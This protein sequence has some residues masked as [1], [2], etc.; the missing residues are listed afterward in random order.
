MIAFAVAATLFTAVPPPSAWTATQPTVEDARAEAAAAFE[1]GKAA[2]EREDFVEAVAQFSVAQAR[3]PHPSTAYNLGL[4]QARAGAPLEA[5]RTFAALREQ[6][7]SQLRADAQRQLDLLADDVAR[8]RV[9]APAKSSLRLDG[10][11]I[12]PDTVVLRRPGPAMVSV[13]GR[14]VRLTLR[15]GEL[16]HLDLRDAPGTTR[17]SSPPSATGLLAATVA[18]TAATAGVGVASILLRDDDI[19]PPLAWTTVGLGTAATALA[20]TAL[21]LR[22]RT[23]RSERTPAS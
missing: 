3:V 14:T 10:S 12:A 20:T 15:G 5:W 13:D 22:L 7:D 16:L 23:R 21:V 17:R 18:T 9:S 6:A 8:I 19:G 4:A 11:E 2:F 1:A